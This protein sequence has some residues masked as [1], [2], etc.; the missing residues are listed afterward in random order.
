MDDSEYQQV[1]ISSEE[2]PVRVLFEGSA[3]ASLLLDGTGFFDCN[4]AALELFR[5]P[6][7]QRIFGL[8]PGLLA[9]VLQTSGR[10]SIS[11]ANE[12][13]HCT[14][15]QGSQ[16]FEWLY[17]RFDGTEFYAQ[18]VLNR[19]QLSGKDIIQVTVTDISLCKQIEQE[20]RITATAFELQEGIL[21]TDAEGVITR[22]NAAFSK[23]SGYSMAE[24]IGETP[25]I[26]C[27]GHHNQQFYQALWADLRT[28]GS[29]Q[30]EIWN[31]HKDGNIYAEWL[32]IT[33]VKS[34]DG[35][36]THYIGIY[37]DMARHGQAE[38][39]IYRL[40]Y[41]DV[42]TNLPNRRLLF[43]RIEQAM[44]ACK[45]VPLH[46]AIVYL[47]LDN[48][49]TLN[50]TC[51]HD[52]GDELLVEVAKRL[53][54]AI[55]E[56][57]TIARMGGDEFVILLE[58]LSE[59]V[60]TATH[61]V[62]LI[63]EKL[64]ELIAAPYD[65]HGMA[66]KSSSSF[67][68]SL[69][70]QFDQTVEDV[71]KQADMAMYEAKRSGGNSACFFKPQMQASLNKRSQMYNELY[72]AIKYLQ[73]SLHYQIQVNHH[74]DI[75]G[76]EALLRWEHP[77]QGQ[78]APGVFITLAEETDI[79]FH[80]GFWVLE[81]VCRQLQVWQT[82]PVL[83]KLAVA[84]NISVRQ[85]KQPGFVNQIKQLLSEYQIKPGQLK[86]ELTEGLLLADV[87]TVIDRMAALKALGI[88]FS[89][90]DFGSGYS[91]LSSLKQLPL[92]QLKIDSS[93]I[94]NINSNPD[95]AAIAKTIIDMAKHL[96]VNVIAEG[97]ETQEQAE[98]LKQFG[99][100][101]FQG[102]L[103]SEPL[104]LA[105]FERLLRNYNPRRF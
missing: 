3:V 34:P 64:L 6:D 25:Q 62:Q 49:K 81:T 37:S 2:H 84:V 99:C 68:I 59:D 93:F 72:D 33:S 32:S 79:I 30:G 24:L 69:F 86:L 19:V 5:I 80:L 4:Q 58:N 44:I 82:D 27:S 102:F 45:R 97:V 10:D 61:Q 76:V 20:L 52:V 35:E 38:A 18:T 90:D 91:S 89:M 7:R 14:F 87:D 78:I 13:I 8:H 22:I 40:A 70:N 46:G 11:L 94:K 51:G 105:A 55:R 100:H 65:L 88:E 92:N 12:Y 26:F 47:D 28:K 16:Q 95:D 41:Y 43:D 74:Q 83:A 75:E 98:L 101:S 21:V 54:L 36:V 96:N 66:F 104:A 56:G 103:Y 71:L 77:S 29:W 9:P 57:D 85:F 48:F 73:L 42:L 17:K 15:R 60:R 1:L 23:I 63:T 31:R 67:G 53:Q 39:A 50:D